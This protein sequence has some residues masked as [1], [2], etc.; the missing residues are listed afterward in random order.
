MKK[1][2]FE[3]VGRIHSTQWELINYPPEGYQFVT[4]GTGQQDKET[5]RK[6]INSAFIPLTLA[7]RVLRKSL[8]VPLVKAYIDSFFK[9]APEG[10]DL[11]FSY[12]QPIFR[13]EP[14]VLSLE[15]V[16]TLVWHNIK[17]LRRYQRV[18]ERLLASNYCKK[19]ITWNQP[20]RKSIL[21]NLDCAQFG[22]KIET[23]PLAVHR[24]EFSKSYDSDKVKLLFVGSVNVPGYFFD[25]GGK[26]VL[27]A[28]VHLSPKYSNL[29]L[30]IR[31]DMPKDTKQ[32]YQGYP[33]I[34]LIDKIIP[35]EQ[36]EQEFKSADIF[37]FPGSHTPWGVILE[38]M[39]YELPV[40]A[41]DIDFTPELIEDGKTGFLLRQ[42]Q[43]VPYCDE[44]FIPLF[45]TPHHK[46]YKER[47]R[48]DSPKLVEEL[49]EKTSILIENPEL[50]RS[51]GK[52]GRWEVEQGKFSIEK[53][54]GKLKRI[55]DEATA[56]G[57]D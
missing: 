23:L 38:A 17:H 19:I 21:L 18:I 30:V 3:T 5:T 16:H 31:S 49:V 26:E 11:T 35:G 57:R 10:T 54:N 6:L 45:H 33:G 2:Y 14:W 8:P 12:N 55:F 34:R 52:A 44:N 42:S 20:A 41:T 50:R 9:K 39:S 32:R 51:M 24:K 46:Q 37:L 28:F 4:E 1:I 29:E 13:K 36:L 25:K 15:C 47:L 53:R 40:I 22:Q 27:E 48:E 56:T 43:R 7:K